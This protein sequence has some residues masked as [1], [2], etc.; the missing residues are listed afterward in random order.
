MKTAGSIAS[1]GFDPAVVPRGI[2]LQNVE[3]RVALAYPA[4]AG[5]PAGSVVLE[6]APGR[7]CKVVIQLPGGL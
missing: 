1:A 2:G 7:G 3:R 6:A 5:N 4:D